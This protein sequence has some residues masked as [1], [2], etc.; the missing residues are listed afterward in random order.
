MSKVWTAAL[1]AVLSAGCGYQAVE[2]GQR[3]LRFDPHN[4]GLK[5]EV[6]QPGTHNLG[7]C[8]LRDC[9]RIDTFDITYQTKREEMHSPSAEGL[10]MELKVAVI[11]RPVVSELYPLATEIGGDYYD[12]VI[13]PEFR[14]AARSVFARH[15][16]TGILAKLQKI[17]D[18]VKEEV[19][20][21]IAGKH[22]DVASVTLESVSYAPEI[23]NAVRAKLV[24]E[25]EAMREKARIENEALR[26]KQVLEHEASAARIK[27][28]NEAHQQR[29]KFDLELQEKRNERAIAEEQAAL[30]KVKAQAESDSKV[31]RAR[32]EAQQIALLA[33][34]HAEENRAAA[35]AHTPLTV[36]TAAYEALGKLGGS[37]T[38]ILLGD[39]SRAPQFLYPR[40]GV[41]NNTYGGAPAM[42]APATGKVAAK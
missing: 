19:R 39:W 14:S 10:A 22:V 27:A 28:E 29:L 5:P 37:G 6:M 8:F 40:S 34:A 13:A 21:R 11:Y 31:V 35:Q 41:F 36:Q 9:G 24:G 32:A 3:G 23:A 17:E 20:R 7:W 38:T 12:E 26:K 16:Y 1:A 18:E 33:K 25:Q 4:G 15:S 30:D 2:A 42:P